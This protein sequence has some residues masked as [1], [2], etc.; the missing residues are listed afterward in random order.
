MKQFVDDG[1]DYKQRLVGFGSDGA[2]V[3]MGSERSVMRLL[4]NDCPELIVIKCSCHSLALCASYACEKLPSYL[5]QLMR[6]IY[7]YLSCSPKRSK[8][9]AMIQSIL[10]VQ[11]LKILHPSATRWLS[12]ESVIKRNNE[13]FAEL[14]MFFSF[15]ANSDNNQTA[16]RILCHLNDPMTKPLLLFLEYVLPVINRV[17][18]IFQ[19]ESPEFPNMYNEI[20]SLLVILLSNIC[21]SQYLKKINDFSALDFEQNL[22]KKIGDL[23]WLTSRRT[24]QNR[25]PG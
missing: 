10:E 21:D 16:K 11:P 9:F 2:S 3:M 25:N 12:L 20:K 6:D 7:S 23:H 4:K 8:E 5:E 18:R 17:N 24:A 19:S 13:R 15:Q 14:V 22:Q 1:I